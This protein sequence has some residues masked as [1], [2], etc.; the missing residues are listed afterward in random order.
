MEKL[1]GFIGDGDGFD[2]EFF[3]GSIPPKIPENGDGDRIPKR[4]GD[5]LGTGKIQTLGIFCGK[6]P[7]KPQKT[8]QGW[9]RIFGDFA[10]PSLYFNLV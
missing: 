10:Q 5:T 7:K 3:W 8:G 6:V 9:G 4:S 1:W 2:F